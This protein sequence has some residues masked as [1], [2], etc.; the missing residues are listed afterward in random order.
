LTDARAST[1]SRR[2]RGRGTDEFAIDGQ[3]RFLGHARLDVFAADLCAAC[4]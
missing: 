3:R 4:P 2:R 1:I